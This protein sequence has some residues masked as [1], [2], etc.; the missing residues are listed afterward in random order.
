MN[1][2]IKNT[3]FLSLIKAFIVA[4]PLAF[5]FQIL[6]FLSWSIMIGHFPQIY[7]MKKV[8]DL[9]Q[10]GHLTVYMIG[11]G[12][13]FLQASLPPTLAVTTLP[14]SFPPEHSLAPASSPESSPPQ[15]CLSQPAAPSHSQKP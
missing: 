1:L 6:F 10:E 2:M 14:H 11:F 7:D 15:S 12:F 13:A 5:V 8:F 4:V 3:L 9:S